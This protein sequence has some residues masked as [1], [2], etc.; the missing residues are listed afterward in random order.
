MATR[1]IALSA[2]LEQHSIG[3]QDMSVRSHVGKPEA[4]DDFVPG[5]ADGATVAA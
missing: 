2:G 5:I 4:Q 3:R 1:K